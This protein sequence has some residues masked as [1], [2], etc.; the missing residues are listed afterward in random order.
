[1][2]I[3][4][5]HKS[6]GKRPGAETVYQAGREA[7]YIMINDSLPNHIKIGRTSD[8]PDKRA[9]QLS[10]TGLP[11]PFKVYEWWLVKDSVK[12]EHDL[13]TMF[14]AERV[15]KKREFF[16][17]IILSEV[18]AYMNETHGNTRVSLPPGYSHFKEFKHSSAYP[19]Y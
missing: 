19:L 14:K 11:L 12:V 2:W 15:N 13:H 18:I 17:S 5:D 10:T 6:K 8:H 4:M 9:K 16:N 7:I 3:G 1:M